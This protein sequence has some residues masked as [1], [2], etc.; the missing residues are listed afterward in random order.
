LANTIFESLE[1]KCKR[2]RYDRKT[3]SDYALQQQVKDV[4]FESSISWRV[5]L[6]LNSLNLGLGSALLTWKKFKINF[7]QH[8]KAVLYP[9]G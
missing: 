3:F 7:R 6:M 2:G 5:R 4:L 8:V 9:K 1:L